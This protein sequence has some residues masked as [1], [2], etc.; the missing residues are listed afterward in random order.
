MSVRKN[1]NLGVA[2]F[3]ENNHSE[4][5]VG[6][7]LRYYLGHHE[8]YGLARTLTTSIKRASETSLVVFK[9]FSES[10]QEEVESNIK[11]SPPSI[12]NTCMGSTAHI[13]NQVAISKIPRVIRQSPSLSAL[14]LFSR[15]QFSGDVEVECHGISKLKAFQKA[16]VGGILEVGLTVLLFCSLKQ[17]ISDSF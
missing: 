7:S 13:I 11:N 3:P 15:E 1:F 6:D 17:M 2:W 8:K 9:V 14:Y 5:I 16:A 12:Y 4:L 10:S